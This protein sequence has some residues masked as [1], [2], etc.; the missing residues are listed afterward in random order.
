MP[1][2]RASSQ[3]Q[4]IMDDPFQLLGGGDQ[5]ESPFQKASLSLPVNQGPGDMHAFNLD[6]QMQR[7]SEESRSRE[8][9]REQ[10]PNMPTMPAPAPAPQEASPAPASTAPNPFE[11]APDVQRA[12]ST[13]QQP[14]TPTPAVSL[15]PAP[16]TPIPPVMSPPIAAQ[17]QV[18]RNVPGG[19]SRD[20][21][22]MF[23]RAGGLL[24]GGMGVP[25][26]LGG[27]PNDSNPIA[28]LIKKLMGGGQ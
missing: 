18:S 26:V 19:P 10:H 14:E 5:Q 4:G 3:S 12:S 28:A 24:G 11:P 16:F 1:L 6:D 13:P 7:G 27:D 8:T 9:P 23:G 20:P 2:R 25:S 15:P 21:N 17:A 22:M